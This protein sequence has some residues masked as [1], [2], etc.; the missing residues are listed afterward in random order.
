MGNFDVIQVLSRNWKVAVSITVLIMVFCV[1]IIVLV[2]INDTNSTSGISLS[3]IESMRMTIIGQM[4]ILPTLCMLVA[5]AGM[6]RFLEYFAV[7]S[8]RYSAGKSDLVGFFG[9]K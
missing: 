8:E 7:L 3:K 2:S 5:L 9:G 6:I 1:V 4:G